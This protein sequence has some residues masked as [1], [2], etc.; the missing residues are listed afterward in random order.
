MKFCANISFMFK[1]IA[2]QER[3][4]AAKELGFRGVESAYPTVLEN[5]LENVI[6]AKQHSGLDHVLLNIYNGDPT[7]GITNNITF[8]HRLR[9]LICVSNYYF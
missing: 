7:Q 4:F 8:L 5:E 1:E 6:R 2:F 3:Y 9:N